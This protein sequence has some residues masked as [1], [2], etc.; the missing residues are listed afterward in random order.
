MADRDFLINQA[1]LQKSSQRASGAMGPAF[2]HRDQPLNAQQDLF[3]ENDLYTLKKDMMVSIAHAGLD[4]IKSK[5][6]L[7][8]QEMKHLE[9]HQN[10]KN[11][12]SKDASAPSSSQ[13]V[14]D[15]PLAVLK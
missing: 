7:Y 3:H 14:P 1:I 8:K 6:P 2:P 13:I 5:D 12:G 10:A 4:I 15:D 9:S 11:N